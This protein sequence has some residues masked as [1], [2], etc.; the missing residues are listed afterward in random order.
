MQDDIKDP[1]KGN[2]TGRTAMYAEIGRYFNPSGKFNEISFR[3]ALRESYELLK[4]QYGAATD[5]SRQAGDWL[6]SYLTGVIN[7]LEE[8]G[9]A[10]SAF[11]L[12]RAAVNEITESGLSDL[13]IPSSRLQSILAKVSSITESRDGVAARSRTRRRRKSSTPRSASSR[14]RATTTRPS[15]RSPRSRASARA[16]STVISPARRNS[17]TSSS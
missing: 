4:E 8:K 6:I 5:F 16:P 13:V 17:S 2:S 1:F 14:K 11:A 10:H 9:L 12:F 15:T 7:Y 3:K